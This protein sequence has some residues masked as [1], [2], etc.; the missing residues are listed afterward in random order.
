MQHELKQYGIVV[1]IIN[2]IIELCSL[3]EV[4]II[5]HEIYITK[6]C[7]DEVEIMKAIIG[8]WIQW[9]HQILPIDSDHVQ[10][11]IMY[12]VLENGIIYYYI[13]HLNIHEK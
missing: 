4:M 10:S 12:Q 9:H 6:D 11:D 3:R 7:D 1:I 13:E 2:D 5:G 8:D